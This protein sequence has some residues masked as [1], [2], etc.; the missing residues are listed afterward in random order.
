M[1]YAPNR[2]WGPHHAISTGLGRDAW[3]PGWDNDFTGAAAWPTSDL[4]IFVPVAVPRR[5]VVTK[6]FAAISTAS[7]NVDIG[8]YDPAGVRLISTGTTTAATSLTVNTTDTTL[9]PGLYYLAMVA[10][11]TTVQLQRLNPTA[12]ILTACGLLTQQLGAGAALPAT[13]TM[14]VLQTLAY[15]PL[16][17]M[18]LGTVVA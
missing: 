5:V 10:N 14:A 18:L 6:L 15:R 4:A 16:L 3:L 9:G 2:A 12:P 7:G 1:T 11:N 17:A 13:A 8:V